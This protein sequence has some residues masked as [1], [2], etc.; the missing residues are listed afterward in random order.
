MKR[1]IPPTLLARDAQQGSAL[2]LAM[3]VMLIMSI[4]IT[5]MA[6]DSDLDL[7]IS[8]NLEL[9]SDAFNNAETGIVL[10]SEV[11]RQSVMLDWK[12]EEDS[13]TNIEL[14]DGYHLKIINDDLESIHEGG[15]IEVFFE[16]NGNSEQIAEIV[17]KVLDDEEGIFQLESEG[18]IE[19]QDTYSK[20]AALFL[21]FE[22]FG[23]AGMT[24]CEKVD[25]DGTA[26]TAKTDVYSGGS[27]VDG[28]KVEGE[29]KEDVPLKCDPLGVDDMLDD[30]EPEPDIDGEDKKVEKDEVFPED[31]SNYEREDK[32]K[33]GDLIIGKDLLVSKDLGEVDIYVE[34]DLEIDGEMAIKEGTQLTIYVEGDINI[35]GNGVVNPSAQGLSGAPKDLIIYSNNSSEGDV[36]VTIGGT[37][38]F[39]GGIFAPLAE[40]EFSGNPEIKGA[41]RGKTIKDAGNVYF[42]DDPFLLEDW[43]EDY[44]GGY[45]LTNWNSL[46]E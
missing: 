17:V 45:Y 23:S 8:R 25:F 26:Y 27:I 28:G 32:Y 33:F 9:K 20:V 38:E 30:S 11:V 46:Q 4:V 6:T 16:K 39:N 22:P 1:D 13:S 41:I 42:E 15:D 31:F 36:G 2:V 10:A 37:P 5:G 21:P 44:P 24:G 3:L 14:S 35:T 12:E 34:G 7:K 43:A 18:F 19:G 40:V 29:V